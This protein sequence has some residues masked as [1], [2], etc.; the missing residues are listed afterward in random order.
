MAITS[1]SSCLTSQYTNTRI[2]IH[3]FSLSLFL[4]LNPRY[5]LKTQ[6]SSIE[7]NN[8]SPSNNPF[9]YS[10]FLLLPPSNG[11]SQI[12]QIRH[13]FHPPLRFQVSQ[14]PNHFLFFFNL[15]I[16]VFIATASRFSISCLCFFFN[17]I[18]CYLD[19]HQL[20]SHREC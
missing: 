8:G 20:I 16:L 19:F 11:Q 3:S 4:F 13:G 5:S 12:S 15:S 17:S 10:N 7:S 18:F 14:I 1:H 9:P 2:H 6:S